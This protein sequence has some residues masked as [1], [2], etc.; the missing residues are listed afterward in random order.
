MCCVRGGY[1]PFPTPAHLAVLAHLFKGVSCTLSWPS[2]TAFSS[3]LRHPAPLLTPQEPT[4]S[5]HTLCL[6]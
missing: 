1:F 3:S 2:A 6:S 5:S 4:L